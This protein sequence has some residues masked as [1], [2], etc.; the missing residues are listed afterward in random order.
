MVRIY[1]ASQ[2][3]TRSPGSGAWE[4]GAIIGNNSNSAAATL[5]ERSSRFVVNKGLPM[6]KTATDVS[7]AMINVIHGFDQHVFG[8]STGDP[9]QSDG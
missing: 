8:S 2:G 5:V 7:D 6:G 9:G 3:A 4:G 1:D